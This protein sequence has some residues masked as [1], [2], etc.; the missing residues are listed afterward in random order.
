MIFAFT[1]L[2]IGLGATSYWLIGAAVVVDA[3]IVAASSYSAYAGAQAQR[4]AAKAQAQQERI[5]A[6][7]YRLQSE[8][9]KRQAA[10]ENEKAGIAQIQAEQEAQRR[11]R[12]LANDI[13]A[14]YANAAGNG[15]LV[16]AKG[17]DTFAHVLTTTATEA[18]DDLSTIRDNGRMNIWEHQSNAESLMVSA[19]TG[20]LSS[21]SSLIGAAAAQRNA[22]YYNQAKYLGAATAGISSAAS[23]VSSGFSGASYAKRNG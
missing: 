17:G 15:L 3:A 12:I 19:K 1:G 22:K 11:S 6:E 23:A 10:V 18:A 16:D 9:M 13:G 2:A 21:Q 5:A 8:E 4:D 20:M 7:Q 14:A